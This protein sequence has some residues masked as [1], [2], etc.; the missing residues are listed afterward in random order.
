MANRQWILAKR[1]VGTASVSDFALREVPEPDA[2]ALKPGQILMR[3]EVFLHAPT[4]RNWMDEPSNS[5]YPSVDLGAPMLAT[6]GGTVLASQ[7]PRFPAGSRVTAI[8]FW[9]DL[10]VVDADIMP[11]RLVGDDLSLLD[12]MG[13]VGVNALTAYMGVTKVGRPKAGE[14]AVVSGAA[15]STGSV[16]GQILR[17]LGCRVI[18]IAGGAAKC[19]RLVSELGFDAAIDYRSEDVEARLRELAPSGIDVFYDNVGG[20]ILQA[21]VENIAKFGRIVLCGQIAGYNG[22]VPVPGP[23]NMMRLVYGSV[24]VQG[25]LLGDYEADIPAARDQLL[26]WMRSGELRHREDVRSGFN[27][28]PATF[29]DLF[30]G[31]NDGTLIVV[32]DDSARTVP[33]R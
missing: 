32:T 27:N 22:S 24:T 29:G 23:R 13:A 6:S 4:M 21:A 33:Q 20:D 1:P 9:E 8:S 11:V 18:G 12:A 26:A 3:N 19:E 28:L 16:A 15:G 17:I 14:T 2:G 31:S 25:F 5:L 7:N 30:T 10:S